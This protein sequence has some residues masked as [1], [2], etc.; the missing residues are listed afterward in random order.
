LYRPQL[1]VTTVKVVEALVPDPE[2]KHLHCRFV[3][4]YWAF[5]TKIC[6]A[7]LLPNLWPVL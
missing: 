1:E 2:V 5:Q 7:I 6:F 3:F 4:W